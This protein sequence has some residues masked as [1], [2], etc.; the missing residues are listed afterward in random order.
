MGHELAAVSTDDPDAG[1]IDLLCALD[2]HLLVLELKSTYMRRSLKDA[3]I[4]RTSTLRKAGWQLH[5]K[6]PAIRDALRHDEALRQALVLPSDGEPQITAWIVDT[7]IEWDHQA[8]R[9]FLKVSLE[10]VQIALRDDRRW[11]ND[12]NGLFRV[13]GSIDDSKDLGTSAKPNDTLYPDGFSAR[14]FIEVVESAAV[15]ADST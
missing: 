9:G 13:R 8:F 7:S 4:H 1:E 2:G 3:W 11:L 12:P 6:V 15:W 10:E 5:R 14:R